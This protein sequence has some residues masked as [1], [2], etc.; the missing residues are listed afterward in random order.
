MKTHYQVL[1]V[2]PRADLDTI[3]RAFRR[4]AKAHHPDL[5]GGGDAA[6]DHQLKVILA[7]YKVLRDPNLRAE[8]DA[9]LAFERESVRRER[10]DAV[11]QFVAATAV[12]SA[13]L[14]GL[15]ILLLPSVGDWMSRQPQTRSATVQPLP[16]LPS[17][18]QPDVGGLTVPGPAAPQ[19]TGA[20][21][22]TKPPQTASLPE[23]PALMDAASYLKR[24]LD[25][26]RLGD[27]DGA[28]ADFD[29]AVRL[30]PRN[31]D[32]YR[33]RARDLGRRGRWER[34]LADYDRAIRL[35]PNNPALFHDRGL[36][37]QQQGELDGALI[38]LDRAVR[39]SFSDARLY[40]DRGAVWLAKGRY[41]RALADFNQALKLDPALAVAAARRDEA[42]DRKREQR[43]ANDSSV[44]GAPGN[45]TTGTL[46]PKAPSNTP[47][48]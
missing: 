33:Y 25:R 31:A 39:M 6:A 21:P 42:L 11:L 18:P 1:G 19:A 38:D 17:R 15:E 4:A 10:W 24:A 3:K 14:I 32:I 34:A 43:M 41:D 28:I 37:L 29:E 46:P 7:A 45:E 27:L 40:S 2:S 9:Q 16:P 48:R 20:L 47:P 22:P 23:A 30:A 12:L 44:P 26:S 13:I 8:Y 36:A 35:D 5:T